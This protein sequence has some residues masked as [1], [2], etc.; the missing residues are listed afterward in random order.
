SAII[1]LCNTGG[2]Q[3]ATNAIAHTAEAFNTTTL[4]GGDTADGGNGGRTFNG[5]LD[6]VAVFNASLSQ[7]QVLDLYYNGL[8]AA[9]QA[10]TPMASLSTNLFVG[11]SVVLS[12]L[13]LG[14]APFQY[15]WQANGGVLPGATNSSLVL[16]NLTLAASG[17]YSV[18]IS[19]SL[20][21]ST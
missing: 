6:E 8:G 9:P 5:S 3:S 16:T 21:V 20:G 12:E 11:D 19:D 7:Q 10:T 17:N 15:Q 2:V 13:A 18:I 4:I 14:V 1:Y